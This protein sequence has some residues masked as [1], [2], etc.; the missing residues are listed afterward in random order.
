[1]CFMSLGVNA[2]SQGTCPALGISEEGL[3]LVKAL[4]LA[5]M[6]LINMFFMVQVIRK[7]LEISRSN[8]TRGHTDV[9]GGVRL[10]V[11]NEAMKM[12]LPF[13]ITM[14]LP[15]LFLLGSSSTRASVFVVV[16]PS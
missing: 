6:Y 11:A 15:W 3:A 5:V 14:G 10:K 12:A 16:S 7:M 8:H 2:T 13:Q 9:V 1:M 4:P